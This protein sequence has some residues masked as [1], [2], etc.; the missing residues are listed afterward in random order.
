MLFLFSFLASGRSFN[1]VPF[2]C[3]SGE[4]ALRILLLQISKMN[5]EF[6]RLKFRMNKPFYF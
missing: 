1:Q 4:D 2:P 3:D 5:P 6:Q